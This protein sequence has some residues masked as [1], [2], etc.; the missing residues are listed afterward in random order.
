MYSP[1][2]WPCS[3]GLGRIKIAYGFEQISLWLQTIVVKMSE[4]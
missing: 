1:F 3:F 4:I 2:F